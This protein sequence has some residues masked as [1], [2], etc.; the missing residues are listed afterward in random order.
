[1][2][3]TFFLSIGSSNFEEMLLF[4]TNYSLSKLAEI[5]EE[6]LVKTH[7]NS[8]L[9]NQTKELD[10]EKLKILKLADSFDLGELRRGLLSESNII[11]IELTTSKEF[12]N[13]INPSKFEILKNTFKQLKSKHQ[14]KFNNEELQQAELH[15]VLNFFDLLIN[16]NRSVDLAVKG[17]PIE[18][19]KPIL[20]R[21]FYEFLHPKSTPGEVVINVESGTKQLYVDSFTLTQNSAVLK[22]MLKENCNPKAN[23]KILDLPQKSLNDM[24]QFISYLKNPINLPGTNLQF[25]FKPIRSH[26]RC[27]LASL[28]SITERETGVG[29]LGWHGSST[30]FDRKNVFFSYF[31]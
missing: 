20:E 28:V 11:Q 5:I 3:F 19:N 31:A 1:M 13:L 16:E 30:G 9:R 21:N 24:A 12:Q 25:I 17:R 22:D 4:S 18:E 29:K 23:G 7:C 10:E 26:Y 27:R 14:N 2:N 6:F 8:W 15:T